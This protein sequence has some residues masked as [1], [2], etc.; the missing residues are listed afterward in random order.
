MK[1]NN[2]MQFK[3]GEGGGGVECLIRAQ[4]FIE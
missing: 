1:L 4:V 2:I 3:L